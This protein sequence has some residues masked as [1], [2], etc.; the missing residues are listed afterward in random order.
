M[1]IIKHFSIKKNWQNNFSINP[2][3]QIINTID[4]IA[5]IFTFK[6][7]ILRDFEYVDILIAVLD[8]PTNHARQ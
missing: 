8:N 5:V 6:K 1:F 2:F 7:K 4:G 3:K